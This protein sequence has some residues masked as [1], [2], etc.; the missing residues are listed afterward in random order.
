MVIY[1]QISIDI[2]RWLQIDID[3]YRCIQKQLDFDRY[4]LIDVYRQV[5][6]Q[7]DRARYRCV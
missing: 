7:I 2:D 6:R 5:D 4:R 1:V 3:S